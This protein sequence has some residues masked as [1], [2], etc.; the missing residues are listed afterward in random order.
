MA[1]GTAHSNIYVIKVE[2]G[3]QKK[4]MIYVYDI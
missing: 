3:V 4:K 2:L 1:T